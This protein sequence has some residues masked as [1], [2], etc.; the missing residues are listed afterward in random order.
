MIRLG[1]IIYPK[2]VQKNKP[3]SIK[4]R[5]W[6]ITLPFRNLYT[7]VIANDNEIE[8]CEKNIW[9]FFGIWNITIDTNINEITNYEVKVGYVR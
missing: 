3:F 1:R 2:S 9:L 6:Y 7:K 5:V 4:Y 8:R